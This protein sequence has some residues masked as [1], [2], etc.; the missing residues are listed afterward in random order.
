MNMIGCHRGG[1]P[2][3]EQQWL[4]KRQRNQKT[5][6]CTLSVSCSVMLCHR[7]TLPTERPLPEGA[8]E[9]PSLSYFVIVRQYRLHDEEILTA[10]HSDVVLVP[11]AG[12]IAGKDT[13]T[14]ISFYPIGQLLL[15]LDSA[16]P[17][18][19]NYK[20]NQKPQ[21]LDFKTL[22]T[23]IEFN[24]LKSTK[25][26]RSAHMCTLLLLLKTAPKIKLLDSN[27]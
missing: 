17:S 5:H 26:L 20:T 2:M 24:M 4:Y 3:I 10:S 1:A 13:S 21:Q 9:H 22:V 8:L 25:F 7:E 23:A 16:G 27:Q 14:I 12:R 15:Q 19:N 11:E 6:T 18:N